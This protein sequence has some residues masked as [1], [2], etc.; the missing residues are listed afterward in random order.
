[1]PMSLVKRLVHSLKAHGVGYTLRA[2]VCKLDGRIQPLCDRR[3]DRRFRVDTCGFVSTDN[4]GVGVTERDAAFYYEPSPVSV[5]RSLLKSLPADHSR[6]T[7]VD[8]GSGK[9]RVLLLASEYEYRQIV[10]VEFSPCLHKIAEKNLAVWSS[11]RQRCFNV[12]SVCMDACDYELPSDP[13]VLFFFTPFRPPVANRVIERL[14]ESLAKSPRSVRILY[15]GSRQDFIDVLARLQFTCR[16]V[17]S[18]GPRKGL[19]LESDGRG[20]PA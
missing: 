3:F 2:G 19:L 11:P 17:Y 15:Y 14:Q 1:M 9:G 5:V 12:K 20:L 7:F 16:Q 4:L 13:L 6:C 18:R 8:F 10:G